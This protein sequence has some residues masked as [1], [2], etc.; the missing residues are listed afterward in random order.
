MKPC[1]TD[2][3]LKRERIRLIE[4]EK[5]VSDEGDLASENLS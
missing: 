1:L 4:N 5:V 2:K 3:T